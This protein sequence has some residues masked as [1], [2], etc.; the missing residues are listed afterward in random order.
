MGL[1]WQLS[2]SEGANNGGRGSSERRST[3]PVQFARSSFSYTDRMRYATGISCGMYYLHS[4]KPQA[5]VHRDLK[6]AN[7]LIDGANCIK[8]ADFG[9]PTLLTAF[10]LSH[11]CHIH[12]I[13]C[14]AFGCGL[15]VLPNGRI[16]SGIHTTTALL[17][18]EGRRAFKP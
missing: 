15:G 2:K 12:D 4:R 11:S 17:I 14:K 16:T 10:A 7:C 9:A 3:C 1:M 18:C 8:I 6:P 13:A 5:I